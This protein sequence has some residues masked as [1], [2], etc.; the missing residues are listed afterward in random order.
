MATL[1]DSSGQFPATIFDDKVSAQ[2]EDA[3]KSGT[4]AL[5]NVDLDRRP[6]EE[7]PRV[8]IRTIQSFE[9]L[10][11]RSRLQLEIA[12]E[13]VAA[14]TAIAAA[15]VGDRGG[16]GQLKLRVPIEGGYADLVL[17][18]DFLLDAET[19]ARIERLDGVT[20]VRLTAAEAPRLAL[21]S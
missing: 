17:G 1:S 4:C 12:V 11:K 13:N 3:A 16:N 14:V 15:V 2:V 21:V 9:S 19:A 8:T 20:S 18:R 5:L 10:S 7:T 6:G